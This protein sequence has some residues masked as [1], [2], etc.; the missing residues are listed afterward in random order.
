M[1]VENL[2]VV[3]VIG[4]VEFEFGLEVGVESAYERGH[5]ILQVVDVLEVG[6]GELG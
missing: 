1:L 6:L 5:R 3:E 4:E 2:L